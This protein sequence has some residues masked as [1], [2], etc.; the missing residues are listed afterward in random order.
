MAITF[1]TLEHKWIKLYNSSE[2]Q[3]QDYEAGNYTE[4]CYWIIKDPNANESNELTYQYSVRTTNNDNEKLGHYYGVEETDNWSGLEIIWGYFGWEWTEYTWNEQI[5]Q[6]GN[7][8]LKI[9][10][11]NVKT[12]PDGD[13]LQHINYFLG[14]QD[15]VTNIEQFNNSNI[16]S[17]MNLNGYR[18]TDTVRNLTLAISDWNNVENARGMFE[19]IQLTIANNTLN[20]PKATDCSYIFNSVAGTTITFNWNF[21][22]AENLSYAFYNVEGD[23]APYDSN[24]FV[25]SK[26]T[27]I[28]YC[29]GADNLKQINVN[30]SQIATATTAKGLFRAR[31]INNN[32][33]NNIALPVCEYLDYALEE[34]DL[35]QVN[36]IN[37]T[38]N[39][40]K[41]AKGLIKNSTIN[42][43]TDTFLD[44]L[45]YLTNFNLVE[46]F[47]EYLM[48]MNH[49]STNN[50]VMFDVSGQTGEHSNV[51]LVDF[52][53]N[54]NI[55]LKFIGNSKCIYDNFCQGGTLTID[56]NSVFT[57]GQS[58]NNMF[59]DTTFN[60]VNL[61]INILEN[62]KEYDNLYN[63]C[64]FNAASE[65][66]FGDVV[67]RSRDI[68][69]GSIF[70]PDFTFVNFDKLN[71]VGL[72][73]SYNTTQDLFDYI[74]SDNMSDYICSD[75]EEISDADTASSYMGYK[76]FSIDSNF[77]CKKI[78]PQTINC[79][80]RYIYNEVNS[81]WYS[82]ELINNDVI[83]D[84]SDVI[85]NFR[86]G[87]SHNWQNTKILIN[88]KS[89]V[90][91]PSFSGS[92]S[93]GTIV[94]NLY[95]AED[96]ILLDNFT[97][98]CEFYIYGDQFQY[99]KIGKNMPRIISLYI[100]SVNIDVNTFI[101]SVN[102]VGEITYI[103]LKQSFYNKL[104]SNTQTRL[105][106]IS[107]VLTL[108]QDEIE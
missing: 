2:E 4:C 49:D 107:R 32:N 9:A 86:A 36:G 37:F 70:T 74:I 66:N 53:S 41:S 33:N 108:L 25:Q 75:I 63:D 80:P 60:S 10:T 11:Q 67:V 34:C 23:I 104:D 31:I 78:K 65:L 55:N 12:I 5:L 50:S 7:L 77:N 8:F 21:P 40:L 26:V 59:L 43:S 106:D 17:A 87:M 95:A 20:L 82:W 29:F 35:S 56:T 92:D 93:F 88:S 102:N 94:C 6:G 3:Q 91:P 100:D 39:V 54:A 19:N 47:G 79:S 64:V 68:L 81:T 48:D 84:M 58:Y 16:I 71:D 13:R 22:L 1:P 42:N 85:L 38:S 51:T 18:P 14:S 52:C 76:Y 103:T 44:S 27:N 61:P 24:Q 72:N 90:H 105:Q 97:A 98:H 45:Q 46:D 28:D 15:S 96:L 101:Q 89:L 30:I 99:L 62:N 69:K 57:G 83:E 73:F